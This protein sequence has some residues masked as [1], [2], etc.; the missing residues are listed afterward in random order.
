M[1]L[2]VQRCAREFSESPEGMRREFEGPR[3]ASFEYATQAA[4]GQVYICVGLLSYGQNL[5]YAV[6]RG[7]M[8]QIN[9]KN[10]SRYSKAKAKI[11]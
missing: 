11:E 3:F 1:Q 6:V 4:T 7:K 8:C 10:V 5:S 2:G 9:F